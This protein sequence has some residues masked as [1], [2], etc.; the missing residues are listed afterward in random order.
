MKAFSFIR[1]SLTGGGQQAVSCKPEESAAPGVPKVPSLL[2]DLEV[3]ASVHLSRTL[4]LYS[5]T[6]SQAVTLLK[7]LLADRC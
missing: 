7:T 6:E 3:S 1:S 2:F 5:S 4:S